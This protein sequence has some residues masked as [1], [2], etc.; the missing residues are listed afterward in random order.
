M[1]RSGELVQWN[2]KG[3]YGFVR[4]GAGNDFYVHVS[5]LVDGQLRPRIGDKLNFEIVSG[6]N[7]R[8]AASNVAV[9]SPAP[10]PTRTIRD[11][12][13]MPRHVSRYAIGLRTAA[14]TMMTL[15]IL[16]AIVTDRV[17]VWL[18]PPM[19]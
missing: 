10:M 2:N 9:A 19:R 15:L 18:G 4:D 14:A 1:S 5:K 17:P 3:G 8:P 13:R 11:I 12:K 6:R 16:L 7:G